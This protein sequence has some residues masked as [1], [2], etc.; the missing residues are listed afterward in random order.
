MYSMHGLTQEKQCVLFI[1][2]AIVQFC[3]RFP[4]WRAAVDDDISVIQATSVAAA[5]AAA[6]AA[7]LVKQSYDRAMNVDLPLNMTGCDRRRS[8]RTTEAKTTI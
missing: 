7:M 6:E 5:A 4:L 8:T 1:P 2:V 3:G